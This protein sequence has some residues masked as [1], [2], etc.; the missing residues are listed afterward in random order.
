MSIA[1]L[2]KNPI[3][4]GVI[5]GIVICLLLLVH[6]KLF[7]KK[8]EERSGFATYF[9]IFL[10]GFISTAPL[11]FLIYNRNISFKM[12]STTQLQPSVNQEADAGPQIHDDAS[13]KKVK[14]KCNVDVP[15]CWGT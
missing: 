13:F 6:D 12:S 4:F 7:I 9:K 11:A 5:A 3:I 8:P 15:D 14:G 2:I 1:D 10:A